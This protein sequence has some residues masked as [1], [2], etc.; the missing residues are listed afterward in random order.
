MGAGG[1]LQ[2]PA[3]PECIAELPWIAGKVFFRD[4][5]FADIPSAN[6]TAQNQLELKLALLSMRAST[7]RLQE[8]IS[9]VVANDFSYGLVGAGVFE[10]GI[11]HRID[12]VLARKRPKPIFPAEPSE[13]SAIVRGR[14]SVKIKL[15][16]PPPLQAILKFD[17]RT[18]E[19]IAY[20][21]E[22]QLAGSQLR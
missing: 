5:V 17:I 14:L 10:F 1:K 22:F 2:R 21:E 9:A 13:D 15:G 20:R 19:A 12:P 11:E 7:V 8:I 16:R 4:E 6:V 3:R 18:N